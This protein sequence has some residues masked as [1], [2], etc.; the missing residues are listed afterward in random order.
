[1]V[2]V[3][4]AFADAEPFRAEW[5]ELVVRSGCDIYQTYEW[6]SVWW[7]HYGSRR[8]LQI[9]LYFLGGELVGVIPAFIE[10]LWLGPVRIRVGKL[11]G[12]DFSIQFCNL[13]VM[14]DALGDSVSSA[15]RHLM[16]ER[17]CDVFIVGPLSGP[18]ARIEEIL[19]C[20]RNVAG[21]VKSAGRRGR[22]VSTRFDLPGTFLEYLTAI[23][24]RQRANYNRSLKRFAGNHQVV[25]DTVSDSEMVLREIERFKS[26]HETQW[27]AEGKLGHFKDWPL[28]TEFNRDLVEIFGKLGMVRFF[29]ILA[30]GR[31]A[32][33]QFC[34]LFA[35]VN[36]W[37]LPGRECRPDWADLSIGKM[38]LIRMF[39][40]CISH[41][42]AVVEGGRGHY[43]YK[44]QLGG[45]EWPLATIQFTR[46]GAGVGMRVRLFR[47]LAFLLNL[48]YYKIFFIRLAPEVPCLRHSLWPVWI[49]STW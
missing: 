7:R 43:D 8:Q 21:L 35:G 33:S 22:S 30:D 49:R 2:R 39:E 24:S 18:A 46:R 12:S 19:A 31:V 4:E 15:I 14:S 10:N 29:R 17:R 40:A 28:A 1:M 26:L 44:L 34:L 16:G 45:Q 9:L 37:R 38:G 23:G 41:G 13:A 5:N 32:S 42:V 20:G 6:C 3:I 27:A 48:V 25:T 36:Y 11:I 47:L